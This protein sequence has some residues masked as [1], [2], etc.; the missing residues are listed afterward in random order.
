MTL[1]DRIFN[2]WS[3]WKLIATDVS[4]LKSVDTSGIFSDHTV[5]Q[6]SVIV[7]I[8]EKTHKFTGRVKRKY[9]EKKKVKLCK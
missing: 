7:D 5:E 2:K 8:Y 9:I 3:D 4:Y 1:Y 6:K